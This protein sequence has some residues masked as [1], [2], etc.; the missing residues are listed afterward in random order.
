MN[1]KKYAYA[2]LAMAAYLAP[3]SS[4]SL[5]RTAKKGGRP[6]ATI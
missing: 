4:A 5:L 6:T 2:A 1:L 3:K